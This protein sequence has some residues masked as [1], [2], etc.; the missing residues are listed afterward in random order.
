M[1][2]NFLH[3]VKESRRKSTKSLRKQ[4]EIRPH[5]PLRWTQ[6]GTCEIETTISQ[7]IRMQEMKMERLGFESKDSIF[8]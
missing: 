6:G 1:R 4:K 7:E 2:S 8:N 5:R 3:R